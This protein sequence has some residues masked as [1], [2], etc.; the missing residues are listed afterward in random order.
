MKGWGMALVKALVQSQKDWK[1]E[2]QNTG[3]HHVGV[4]STSNCSLKTWRQGMP[5]AGCLTRLA[6]PIS[7]RLNWETL[8]QSRTKVESNS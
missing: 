6:L 5:E 1:L 3:K 2:P 4:G 7:S 8:L